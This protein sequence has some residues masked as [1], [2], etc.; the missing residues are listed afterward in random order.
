M[1]SEPK[2]RL[3]IDGP[4]LADERD[5]SSSHWAYSPTHDN[6]MFITVFDNRQAAMDKAIEFKLGRKTSEADT[7]ELL[8]GVQIKAVRDG[9]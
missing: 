6:F 8:P 4:Q 9:Q 3:H 5:L 1:A 7:Y 2:Y